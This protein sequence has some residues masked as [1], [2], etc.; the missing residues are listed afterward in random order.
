MV[1]FSRVTQQFT[2]DAVFTVNDVVEIDLKEQDGAMWA[3]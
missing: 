2:N 1:M 3:E